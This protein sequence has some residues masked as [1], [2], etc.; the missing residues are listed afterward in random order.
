MVQGDRLVE[1]LAKL[2]YRSLYLIAGPQMLD[3]M[4]RGHRL[5]RLYQ[6]ISLQLL[7]GESFHTL[8]PG[9]PLGSDGRLILRELYYDPE[10]N[11]HCAQLFACFEVDSSLCESRHRGKR[12]DRRCES[13]SGFGLK[14]ASN[15]GCRNYAESLGSLCSIQT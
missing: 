13:N 11:E 9:P 12:M 4:L 7:G 3:T 10:S 2:G 8:L 5:S 14:H 6:T 15:I 1:E